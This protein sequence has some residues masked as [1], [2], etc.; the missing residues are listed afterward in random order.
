MARVQEN[1]KFMSS[2][3]CRSDC[4]HK[5]SFMYDWLNSHSFTDT[6]EVFEYYKQVTVLAADM[7]EKITKMKFSAF[8]QIKIW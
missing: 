5:M 1:S 6:S 2:L 3:C 8:K 7:D 4:R